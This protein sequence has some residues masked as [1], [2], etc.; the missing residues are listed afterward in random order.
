MEDEIIEFEVGTVIVA[1]GLEVFDPTGLTEYGYTRYEN[2]ITSLEFERL[3]SSSGPTDGHFVRPTDMQRP[4]A[5]WFYPMYRLTHR[6]AARLQ[7]QSRS[8]AGPIAPMC[9]A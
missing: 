9:A 4:Q 6:V 1:T 5:D 8:A 3:I 7:R 2:I